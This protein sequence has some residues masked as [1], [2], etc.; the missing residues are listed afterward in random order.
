MAKKIVRASI[1]TVDI[2]NS[3]EDI[4]N[5]GPNH[6]SYEFIVNVNDVE[7]MISFIEETFNKFNIPYD[8]IYESRYLFINKDNLYDKEKIYREIYKTFNCEEKEKPRELVLK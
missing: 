2:K 4:N 8:Y 1:I 6:L 3:I 7:N 5:G